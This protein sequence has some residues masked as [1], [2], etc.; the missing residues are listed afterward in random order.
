[1]EMGKGTECGMAFEEWED[2]K[3]GDLVQCYEEWEEKRKL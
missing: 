1:M 3:P 2:F